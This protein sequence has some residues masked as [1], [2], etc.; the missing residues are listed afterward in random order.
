[1]WLKQSEEGE[2]L[3][4]KWRGRARAVSLVGSYQF[5]FILNKMGRMGEG[6]PGVHSLVEGGREHL[7]GLLGAGVLW[8]MQ[9]P[10]KEGDRG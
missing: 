7:E 6:F 9:C 2:G 10:T 3:R 8:G 4:L 1:M 5:R